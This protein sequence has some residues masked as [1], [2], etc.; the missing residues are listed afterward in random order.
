MKPIAV[1][2]P[3]ALAAALALPA[4]AQVVI[5]SVKNPISKLTKDQ[6][7]QIFLGQ[8][9]TFYTGGQAEPLDLP[10][11]LDTRNAFYQKTLNKP[12]AQMKAFWAK[13]EFSGGAHAPKAL[14]AAEVV[15]LV[16]SNPKFIGYVEA[17]ALTP[18]VKVVFTP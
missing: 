17:S 15:K 6:V 3:L 8:A 11:G 18:E 10:D 14:S 13:M 2:A 12:S 7:S 4:Q 5:V 9:K 1:F 16:A